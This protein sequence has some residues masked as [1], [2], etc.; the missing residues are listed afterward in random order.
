MCFTTLFYIVSWRDERFGLPMD[1]FRVHVL[2]ELQPSKV[3]HNRPIFFF[4]IANRPKTKLNL[5]FC[6]IKIAHDHFGSS[7]ENTIGQINCCDLFWAANHSNV[8]AHKWH[9]FWSYEFATAPTFVLES[10][11]CFLKLV[12]F[13]NSTSL[14]T[15]FYLLLFTTCIIRA[16][17]YDCCWYS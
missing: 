12:E 1:C 15:L 2:L 5:K 8:Y 14:S 17:I 13:K 16:S 10:I 4:S 11:L 7:P 6:F 9:A 3:A